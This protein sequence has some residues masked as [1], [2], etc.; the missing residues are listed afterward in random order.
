MKAALIAGHGRSGTNWLLDI[1]DISSTT[2]CANERNE[3]SQSLMSELPD[4]SINYGQYAGLEGVW[5]WVVNET[6]QRFGERDPVSQSKDFLYSGLRGKLLY[7][8]RKKRR[9]RALMSIF[10]DRLSGPEWLAPQF[11]VKQNELDEALLILKINQC[12][13]LACWLLTY[14]AEQAVV[15]HIL[16][17]P[18]GVLNSWRRR[19]LDNKNELVVRIN[20]RN[21]LKLIMELDNKITINTRNK[22]IDHLNNDR[23]NVSCSEL[24]YWLYANEKIYDSGNKRP[25]YILI[26][27]D[28]LAKDPQ[29]ITKKVYSFLDLKLDAYVMERISQEAKNSSDIATK[30]QETL[31]PADRVMVERVLEGSLFE[32]M[33]SQEEPL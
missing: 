18:G 30:W 25:N 12:P 10:N 9:L 11:L 29:S 4:P 3:I 5:D 26:N 19:F 13:A 14:F 1:L 2:F 17:H 22:M 7:L 31:S 8:I 24:L 28:A 21:R 6:K 16:R 27:Y 23:N 33:W 20:N 32:K 15:I